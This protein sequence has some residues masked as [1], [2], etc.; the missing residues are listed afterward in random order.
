MSD[1]DEVIKASGNSKHPLLQIVVATLLTTVAGVVLTHY[2]QEREERGRL[3]QEARN[4]AIA[5]YYD[6]I[7]TCGKRHYYAFRAAKAF[8]VP[9]MD[10]AEVKKRWAAYDQMVLYWNDN[11][12]R[13]VAML[14]RYFGAEAANKNFMEVLRALGQI[15][16]QLLDIKYKYEH[17][18]PYSCTKLLT[19]IEETDGMISDFADFLEGKLQA[20][21]VDIY[22]PSPPTKKP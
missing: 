2:Y 17:K 21:T 10:D 1:T 7:D 19:Q 15:H 18:Q 8:E 6:M 11:R 4:N 13:N 14:K 12:F 16:G 22:E 20:G 9:A 3:L 5:V